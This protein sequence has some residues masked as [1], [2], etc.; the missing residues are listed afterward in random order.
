MFGMFVLII[1]MRLTWGL[2]KSVQFNLKLKEKVGVSLSIT[3]QLV[4]IGK[5]FDLLTMFIPLI[6]KLME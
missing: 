4:G 6:T 1:Q 2:Y 5:L 3:T